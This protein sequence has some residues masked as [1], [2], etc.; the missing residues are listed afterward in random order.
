MKTRLLTLATVLLALAWPAGARGADGLAPSV[1]SPLLVGG[2]PAYVAHGNFDGVAPEDIA[3]LDPAAKKVTTYHGTQQGRFV[4]DD[5]MTTLNS[6]TMIAVGDFNGDGDPDLAVPNSSD[7][8]ISLFLGTSGAQF[9][10]T[11]GIS[12]G[13]SP[14]NVVVGNFDGNA[15]PD[16]AVTN[17]L[18]DNLTILTGTGSTAA[19]F[20]P[21]TLAL[22]T[23][24]QP[25]GLASADFNGD[26]DPDLVT[27]NVG[28]DNLTVLTG[29]SN[30]TFAIAGTLNTATAQH[31]ARPDPEFVEADDITGDG[32]PD[33][34]VGHTSSNVISTFAAGAGASFTLGFETSE[35]SSI[36]GMALADLD[37]DGNP[38]LFATASGPDFERL[39]A[40][41]GLASAASPFTS[42]AIYRLP[43]DAVGV[44]AF[45]NGPGTSSIPAGQVVVASRGDG[46]KLS[47]YNLSQNHLALNST[48]A[49]S[50]E[51]GKIGASTQTVTFTNDGLDPFTPT[52]IVMTGNADDF[53]ISSDGCRGIAIARSNSCTVAF[54]FAP[55][56]VGTRTV[57]VSIRDDVARY[58]PLDTVTFSRTGLSP[59]SG[60][61]GPA[62]PTGPAGPAGA[63]GSAGAAGATGPAG[64]QG[65]AG[66]AG[67][68]GQTGQAGPQGQT[69]PQ[70]PAGRDARVKCK[71]T[72]PKHSR[73]RV[74][75]TVRL[76]LARAAARVR[77]RLTRH[78]T[79]YASG[80]ASRPGARLELVA[81]RPIRAGRYRLTVVS[82]DR[83]QRETVTRRIVVVR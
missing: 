82:F 47:V 52:A 57:T 38:E 14:Q 74:R 59:T 50:V 51:V 64:P 65:D 3:V 81:R 33:I 28:S 58:S 83:R 17:R 35:S 68:Q 36:A 56:A 34:V 40:R 39:S 63:D 42:R 67:S 61:A 45:R 2:A 48:T 43:A 26:N 24:T 27:G 4:Q 15:D 46:G 78:G 29:G 44:T 77:A 41:K 69:G 75:C 1:D 7:D 72:K 62:G 20:T 60:P 49:E 9:S 18:S 73:I 19:T 54:R 32:D 25:V 22:G 23:G 11:T 55:R 80:R 71:A 12:V 10:P 6:P 37:G 66:P 79:V 5:T 21:A 53:L 31:S 8:N 76:V 13:N 70:G 30:A 16:L